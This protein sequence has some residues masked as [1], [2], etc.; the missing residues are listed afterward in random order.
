MNKRLIIVR[1]HGGLGNQL[2][3]IAAAIYYKDKFHINNIYLDTSSLS[4]YS[5]KR[6][7]ELKFIEPLLKDFIFIPKLNLY[8]RILSRLRL[9]KFFNGR[10]LNY[11]FSSYRY[12]PQLISKKIQYIFIDGYFQ[13]SEIAKSLRNKNTIKLFS[14][15]SYI[16][17]LL[18]NISNTKKIV[19]LH[20]RRG[21]YLSDKSKKIFKEVDLI[22]YKFATKSFNKDSIFLVFGDD[23]KFNDSLIEKL[24][25]NKAVFF[26]SATFNLELHEEFM[27]LCLCDHY[28]ISN[29]TFSWWAAFLG[30]SKGKRV[31]SPKSWYQDKLRNEKN[32]LIFKYFELI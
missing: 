26:N 16:F 1:L 11:F 2:F 24:E 4:N 21:D 19:G 5:T 20:V 3:Q 8:L 29:S 27:L 25:E 9:P 31:I 15:Y 7:C 28:I 18:R 10:I 14:K 32:S 12:S 17:N 6:N 30:Y 22:Y 23:Y 13:D